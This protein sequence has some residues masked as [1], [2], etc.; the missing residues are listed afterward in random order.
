M[1]EESIGSS[2]LMVTLGRAIAETDP[3]IKILAAMV[4]GL[5]ALKASAAGLLAFGLLQAVVL[6]A[7]SLEEPMNRSMAKAYILFVV[8]WMAIKFGLDLWTGLGWRQAALVSGELGL[9]LAV[10]LL[11]GLSLALA[12][13][14]RSLGLA[15]A[16]LLRPILRDRAWRAALSMALFVHFLPLV[17][18]SIKAVQTSFAVRG[19]KLAWWR[20]VVL[21]TQSLLRYW[22]QKAWK[23]TLALATR[24]LDGPEAW[25]V[26]LGFNVWQWLT[27]LAVVCLGG[28]MLLMG[29][30]AKVT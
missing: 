18:H 30:M 11:I 10:L 6:L 13:S 29:G 5:L 14:P 9:R 17:W 27:G 24:G 26:R 1:A 7:V 25:D 12:T 20:R 2:G 23:Q 28:G 8:V 4:F 21:M 19:L 16:S 15:L 22:S 3:R